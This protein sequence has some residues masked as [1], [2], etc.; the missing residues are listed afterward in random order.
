MAKQKKTRSELEALILEKLRPLP[1][2]RGITAVVVRSGL[3][4]GD[5]WEITAIVR[6]AEATS[7]EC[8]AKARAVQHDL[9]QVFDL[10]D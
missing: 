4:N 6:G 3:S 7:P 8:W 1:E 10:S 5:P 2:C 9:R